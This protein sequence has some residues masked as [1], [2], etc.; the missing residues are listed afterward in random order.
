[1]LDFVLENRDICICDDIMNFTHCF[2][3]EIQENNNADQKQL[4]SCEFEVS[5]S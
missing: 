3:G 2:V 4:H 5:V 1:M